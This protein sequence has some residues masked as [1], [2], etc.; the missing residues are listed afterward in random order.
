MVFHMG[1]FL[2][3]VCLLIYEAC[4]T[5]LYSVFSVCI[6]IHLLHKL[7][8]QKRMNTSGVAGEILDSLVYP[9]MT[10]VL[11]ESQWQHV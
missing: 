8:H 2:C 3:G 9:Q 7:P 11:H 4:G 5:L 1:L 6:H 10:V